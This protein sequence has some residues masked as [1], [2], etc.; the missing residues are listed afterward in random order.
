MMGDVLETAS[1]EGRTSLAEVSGCSGMPR[2]ESRLLGMVES[3]QPRLNRLEASGGYGAPVA[4][5]S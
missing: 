2:Y 1:A 3:L 5:T 4:V